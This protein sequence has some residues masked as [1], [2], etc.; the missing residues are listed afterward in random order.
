MKRSSI[1]LIANFLLIAAL[2]GCSVKQ[3]YQADRLI[4]KGL[5]DYYKDYFPIGVAVGPQTLKGDEAELLLREFNSITAENAMKMGP[6]HPRENE[7][8]WR[9]ADSIVNFAQKHG[10]RV[11]GHNLLWHEQAPEWMFKDS[12]GNQV[13]RD[14]LLAR[15]KD[16]IY[17]VVKRYKGKIYAWDVVNEAID[18]NPDDFLRK[19]KWLEIIGEDFIA[20]AFQFAHEADPDALLFYNDYNTERPE[21]RDRIYTLLKQLVDA[22]VPIH[23]VGLQAHWSIFEPT[24]KELREAIEKYSSL[25]LQIHFTEVDM[26]VYPWEKERRA[27]RS[28]ENDQLTPELEQK[29][30]AQYK[31]VFDI[32]REYRKHITSVTFWNVSDRYTWLDTYPV[33]G[34]KNYPLLF[35]T[36][37]ERKKAYWEVVNFKK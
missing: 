6:I 20:K 3:Q 17:T 29:Q 32:F 37:L 26:S 27:K 11:R 33:S 36:K 21:K 22:K 23:G 13:S 19:T 9:D 4:T 34:R 31:M 12:Q 15:L 25:G 18:D 8:F 10:L 2:A 28:G 16:H 5:K 24:E 7:Y 1:L 35:D 14:V 30:I